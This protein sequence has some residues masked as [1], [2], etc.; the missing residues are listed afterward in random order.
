LCKG[1]HGESLSKVERWRFKID[2]MEMKSNA[3]FDLKKQS[4]SFL[5][6]VQALNCANFHHLKNS[7]L[8]VNQFSS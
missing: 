8:D 4:L 2:R 1:E 7:T 5:N 3:F 6:A